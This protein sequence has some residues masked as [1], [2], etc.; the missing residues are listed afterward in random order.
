M[1]NNKN[2][3]AKDTCLKIIE[4]SQYK[5]VRDPCYWRSTLTSSPT[6]GT[7]ADGAWWCW[8]WRCRWLRSSSFVWI[9]RP[10]QSSMMKRMQPT[11]SMNRADWAQR[12][13]IR[14]KT[15]GSTKRA[16]NIGAANHNVQFRISQE[17]AARRTRSLP[18]KARQTDTDT[19][20]RSSRRSC[21]NEMVAQI[22]RHMARSEAAASA[23]QL[24][25]KADN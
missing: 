6:F 21:R 23:R 2:E 3:N 11:S 19:D 7:D 9:P 12:T 10:P 25:Q 24:R 18:Q 8:W 14:R 22:R 20:T 5:T 1:N 15:H 13:R 16:K 4:K 17:A